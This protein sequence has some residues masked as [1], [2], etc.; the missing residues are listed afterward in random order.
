MGFSSNWWIGSAIAGS[1]LPLTVTRAGGRVRWPARHYRIGGFDRFRPTRRRSRTR[2][3]RCRCR[4]RSRAAGST[5]RPQGEVPSQRSRQPAEAAAGDDAGHEL[6]RHAE[7]AADRRGIGAT[8]RTR[9][10]GRARGPL[11]VELRF[12]TLEPRGEIAPSATSADPVLAPVLRA[13]AAHG[14]TRTIECEG[15][16]GAP[17]K[18]AHHSFGA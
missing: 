9:P 15:G 13:V 16:A 4:R 6:R 10:S 17:Q 18:P 14:E 12:E 11:P 5:I 8:P 2:A 1:V 7:R 3:S